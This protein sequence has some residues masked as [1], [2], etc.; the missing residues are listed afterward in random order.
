MDWNIID[1]AIQSKSLLKHNF[2]QAWSQGALTLDDLRYYAGQYYGL[3]SFFPRLISRIH[4]ML[5]KPEDRAPLLK[6]LNDEEGG[7]HNHRQLW[8][9]FAEGLGLTRAQAMDAQLNPLTQACISSLMQL[10]SHA[11]PAVG[12]AALYAYESQLPEISKSKID[13]LKRFYGIEDE[14]TLRFFEVHREMDAWHSQQEK[15]LIEALGAD[16]NEVVAAVKASCDALWTFLD[17]VD[18][19]TRLKRSL[20]HPGMDAVTQPTRM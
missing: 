4:S 2:Y 20:C 18:E 16:Q 1:S 19:A 12:L 6:N 13:G 9:D 11:N 8:L 7:E 17:G 14:K 15:D 5:A 10:A 3:E